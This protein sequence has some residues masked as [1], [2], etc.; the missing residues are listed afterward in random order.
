MYV[1]VN[2]HL[3]M[4][5]CTCVCVC[6]RTCVFVCTCVR[7]CLCVGTCVHVAVALDRAPV[8]GGSRWEWMDGSVTLEGSMARR[9][10]LSRDLPRHLITSSSHSHSTPAHSVPSNPSLSRFL[11]VPHPDD[12]AQAAS[13]LARDACFSGDA[14]RGRER[15]REFPRTWGCLSGSPADAIAFPGTLIV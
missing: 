1:Y 8:A 5:L 15:D 9:I 14:R 7:V 6:A 12:L 13:L 11:N 4:Y 2:I 3:C 10:S